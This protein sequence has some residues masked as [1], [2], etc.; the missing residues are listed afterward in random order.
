M[1]RRHM[2]RIGGYSLKHYNFH[3]QMANPRRYFFDLH[4]FGGSDS[5][6]EMINKTKTSTRPDLLVKSIEKDFNEAV[7]KSVDSVMDTLEKCLEKS[8]KLEGVSRVK[9]EA[10]INLGVV[11]L[12]FTVEDDRSRDH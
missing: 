2:L 11:Q 7:D 4:K 12:S 6:K 8:R 10:T 5:L 1:F 3:H 9:A